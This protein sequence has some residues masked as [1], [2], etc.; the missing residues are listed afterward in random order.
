[1]LSLIE[2]KRFK[3]LVQLRLEL[4]R[5][6]VFIGANGS[7][8]S[9][10]LEAIGVLG[11]AAFGRVDDETL[12]RRGVRPGLPQL[13]KTQFPGLERVP[14]IFLR[15]RAA[16]GADYRVSLWNPQDD[17]NPAW[18]FKTEKLTDDAGKT[19]E[20][21]DPREGKRNREQ[22]KVALAMF[23][24]ET[25]APALVLVDLLRA[26]GIHTPNTPVLRGLVQDLQS[27]EPVGLA[28][29]RLPESIEELLHLSLKD[30]DVAAR[31]DQVRSLVDWASDFSA[32]ASVDVPLSPSA[33]RSRLVVRFLDKFMSRERNVLTGYDASEGALYVL[34]CAALALHPK[35]P[36][37]LALDNLDQAINPVLARKLIE[38]LCSWLADAVPPR[39][40][41]V[42]CHNP[43][44][45]DGLPLD[46]PNVRLFSVD[47]DSAGHTTVRVIDLAEAVRA[48]PSEE[49][50]LSRMWMNGLLG[51]VPNA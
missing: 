37:F 1:M 25:D 15:G 31:L 9:N 27:R 51:G 32:A 35:S 19:I 41:L 36:R 45:L 18:Q 44:I 21:R 4:G 6:N 50:T 46:Q 10:I 24:L 42:T 47:R 23:R 28:G 43:A 3:S 48:R 2:V 38:L 49:W 34:Y 40:W 17:P 39:Q 33:A 13:Y 26:Y 20:T 11:A 8:K 16:S 7:G 14:H 5:V 29:G 22:G 30:A 12:L